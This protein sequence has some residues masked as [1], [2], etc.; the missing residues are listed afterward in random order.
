MRGGML[1]LFPESREALCRRRLNGP[2]SSRGLL[3]GEFVPRGGAS[4]DEGP[5]TRERD[6]AEAVRDRLERDI[7][8]RRR[9]RCRRDIFF[10]ARHQQRRAF[11]VASVFCR[12]RLVRRLRRR[13]HGVHFRRFRR[14]S[15]TNDDD[16]IHTRAREFSLL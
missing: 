12:D 2:H 6:D 1:L 14:R 4:G 16:T 15:N 5:R 13:D 11:L 10:I 9:F 8:F 3:G 7:G